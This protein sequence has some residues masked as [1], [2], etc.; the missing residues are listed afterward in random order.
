MPLCAKGN[1][2]SNPRKS[3]IHGGEE[4]TSTVFDRDEKKA[5][6]A[7][8]TKGKKSKDGQGKVAAEFWGSCGW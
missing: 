4:R 1:K 8:A 3:G 7:F 6:K 5:M 2:C